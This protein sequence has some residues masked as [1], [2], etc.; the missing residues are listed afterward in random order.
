MDATA[1]YRRCTQCEQGLMSAKVADVSC[2][3]E[4]IALYTTTLRAAVLPTACRRQGAPC[5]TVKISQARPPRTQ[6]QLDQINFKLKSICMHGHS[7]AA[8]VVDVCVFVWPTATEELD[9]DRHHVYEEDAQMWDQLSRLLPCAISYLIASSCMSSASCFSGPCSLSVHLSF[10]SRP[11]FRG[12]RGP[13]AGTE[14]K[15]RIR[16]SYARIDTSGVPE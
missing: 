8:Y 3:L 6:K 1:C 15:D 9:G 14:P 13:N 16:A 4:Q 11:G 5:R 12:V 2:H 10:P 7:A